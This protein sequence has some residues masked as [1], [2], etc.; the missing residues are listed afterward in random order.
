MHQTWDNRSLLAERSTRL[1]TGIVC[2]SCRAAAAGLLPRERV[3]P[4]R[5][6]ACALA[7]LVSLAHGRQAGAREAAQARVRRRQCA[8]RARVGA[9]VAVR[10]LEQRMDARQVP[11][12]VTVAA[13]LPRSVWP[14][15]PRQRPCACCRS[16]S[17][18][19]PARTPTPPEPQ[20]A[21]RT[22]SNQ[23]LLCRL[24]YRR[25]SYT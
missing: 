10:L 16:A 11:L 20:L 9:C 1:S 2:V 8:L 18:S 23:H 6:Q 13:Q 14:L 25:C 21:S 3:A 5:R 15:S 22:I 7:P 17:S 24:L 12:R 19:I 4:G